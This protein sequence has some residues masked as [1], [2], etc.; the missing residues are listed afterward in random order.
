MCCERLRIGFWLQEG[1][2]GYRFTDKKGVQYYWGEADF[3]QYYFTDSNGL[4]IYSDKI[5]RFI[6]ESNRR[7]NGEVIGRIA[8]I[9]DHILIDEVQDLAGWDLELLKLMCGS[10]VR[11][12]MV[13]DP[14][15]GTYA[16]NDSQKHKKYRN[17]GIVDFFREKCKKEDIL[18][19][20]ERLL[21]SHRNCADICE[22]SSSL[23]PSLRKSLPCDCKRCRCDAPKHLGVYL[24]RKEHV[25][26]YLAQHNPQ[27][28]K[29]SESDP[30]ELNFGESKG[31]GFPRVLIYPTKKIGE[32][33]RTGD[34]LQIETVL[35]K[36]YVAI[37]RA[38]YSVGIV[39]DF[40]EGEY[41]PPLKKYCP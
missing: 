5:S 1:K 2:S 13:G 39:M 32:F 6:F 33:L 38:R 4:K 28:L 24:V 19:D 31:L 20:D 12:L 14:R 21:R 40:D 18:I 27:V 17:T 3:F 35:A 37:T 8:R 41:V 36:F 23:Y 11:L 30:G 9:F 34:I 22:F 29:Y 7:T 25:P 10:R 26:M 16:T 15:Q